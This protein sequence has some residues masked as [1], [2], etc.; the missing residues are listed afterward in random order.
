MHR[1]V[2][3]RGE[4][5]RGTRQA[6]I[7]YSRKE[8]RG[9]GGEEKRSNALLRRVE[10]CSLGTIVLRTVVAEDLVIGAVEKCRCGCIELVEKS[11]GL[12]S[13]PAEGSGHLFQPALS[14]AGQ[15]C[16]TEQL[17]QN[18]PTPGQ[19]MQPLPFIQGGRWDE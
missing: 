9:G 19:L 1:V 8:G 17:L 3:I 13:S 5:W 10:A 4:Y 2:L 7:L 6:T 16:C 12:E 14:T 15:M 18:C 11:A